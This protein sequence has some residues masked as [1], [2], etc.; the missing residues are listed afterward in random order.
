MLSQG[1][2]GALREKVRDPTVPVVLYELLPPARETAPAARAAYVECVADLLARVPGIDAINVPEIRNESRSGRP[3]PFRP[4]ADPRRFV[5]ELRDTL[6][7]PL[8]AV[9]N[10]GTVYED[11]ATQ[12]RWLEETQAVYGIEN[13]VLVGG[14]SSRI[15]YPGPSV[16]EMARSI[17][18]VYDDALFCGGITIPTRRHRV[19]NARK[20]EPLRLLD[21][22]A[23]GLEFF[24][25]QVLYE[26]ESA[27]QLLLDYDRLCRERDVSPRRIFLSFAPASS[28]K[29]IAFLRWLGVEIPPAVEE[30]LLQTAI[31]IGWRSLRLARRL[32]Q[33]LLVFVREEGL[34]VPLGLN[35]EHITLRNFELSKEFLEQLGTLYRE[36]WKGWRP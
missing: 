17:R 8:E 2:A 18:H 31:G 10:H 12:Q 30:E 14:E 35:V 4:K 11:W 32:L 22:A 6:A 33:D 13:L 19:G 20:D 3:E 1:S 7:V 34:R 9:V 21:K 24:T 15:R 36:G 25:S 23:C 29:E 26:A 28:R 5:H 16:L 27:R